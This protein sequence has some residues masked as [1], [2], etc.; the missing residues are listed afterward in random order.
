MCPF[1]IKTLCSAWLFPKGHRGSSANRG[2][3]S[4]GFRFAGLFSRLNGSSDSEPQQA[5]DSKTAEITQ[6]LCRVWMSMEYTRNTEQQKMKANGKWLWPNHSIRGSM[7]QRFKDIFNH[8]REVFELSIKGFLL[9]ILH[10][11]QGLVERG[12]QVINLPDHHIPAF[13]Q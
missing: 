8:M 6:R 11:M 7:L 4:G 1:T 9:L 5:E 13:T 2:E 12:I 3:I 10:S